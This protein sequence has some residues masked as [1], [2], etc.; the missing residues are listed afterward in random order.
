MITYNGEAYLRESLRAAVLQAEHFEEIVLI[1]NGSTDASLDIVEREF[2]TVRVVRVGENRGPGGARNA[3]MRAAKSDL[4]LF[5]DND[6]TLLAGCVE[7]L[8]AALHSHPDAIVAA[9]SV[10]YANDPDT[11]QYCGADNH[12]LGLMIP[13]QENVPLARVDP[14]IRRTNSV[15]TACFLVDRARLVDPEPF[16]ELYFIYWDD[17]DFGMRQRALGNAILAVPAAHVLHGEG[18]PG[19]SIRKVGKYT[20]RRIYLTIRNRWLFVLKHYTLRS[21]I[22]LSPIF[23]VYECAQLVIMVKKG[24]L[25]EW[26]RAVGWIIRQLPTVLARRRIV[27]ATRKLPDRE[28]FSDGPI[29]F[30]KELASGRLELAAKRGLD[31]I[32]LRYWQA[33]SRIL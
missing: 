33:V 10:I 24:W 23:L 26:M 1:D 27:Q 12:F 11:I 9:P 32:S 15:I 6:V 18:Q 28:V 30:R 3:G 20:P 2:P 17:H 14:T 7:R 25:R 13:R 31:A 4:I 8:V 5:L 19:L 16:D 22:L 21:L 29:P